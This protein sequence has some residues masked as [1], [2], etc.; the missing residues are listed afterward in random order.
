MVT[1]VGMQEDFTTALKELIELDYDAIEAYEAAINRLKNENYKSV[2]NEFKR[3]HQ[4]HIQEL[5]DFLNDKNETFPTGPSS[6]SILTQGKV[7]LANLMGDNLILRAMR[8]NEID[9]N[10]AYGRINNYENIP[11]ELKESLK[12]GL[13]DEKRHLAW[14]EKT[15]G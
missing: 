11:E 13:Q 6:K 3:D 10:T 2:L 9:T 15:L 14:I 4:R 7:V 1:K 12:K 8:S 5:S